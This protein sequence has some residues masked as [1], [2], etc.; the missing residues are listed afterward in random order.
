MLLKYD[1]TNPKFSVWL[2]FHVKYL[3]LL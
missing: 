1:K 2:V 3:K